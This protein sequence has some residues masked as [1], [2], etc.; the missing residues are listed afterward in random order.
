MFPKGFTQQ[1][2]NCFVSSND[3]FVKIDNTEVIRLQ[4]F[5]LATVFV[6]ICTQRFQISTF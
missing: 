6:E 2:P 4:H 3:T 5:N 1:N